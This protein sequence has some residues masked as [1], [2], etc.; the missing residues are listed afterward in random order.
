M[1]VLE[2]CTSKNHINWSSKKDF[3][4]SCL[5]LSL[6]LFLMSFP[7]IHKKTISKFPNKEFSIMNDSN[8]SR[9]RQ[10]LHRWT[11][12]VLCLFR[13][14]NRKSNELNQFSR[15][16]IKLLHIQFWCNLFESVTMST[17]LHWPT[18]KMNVTIS[19]AIVFLRVTLIGVDNL[20]KDWFA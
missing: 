10:D 12:F 2:P 20:I 11:M 14:W 8:H 6:S 18:R 3:T 5:S 17:Y 1:I 13:R 16:L 4:S 7:I 19:Y 15:L 9:L